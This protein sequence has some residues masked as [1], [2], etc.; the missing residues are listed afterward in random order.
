MVP[1]WVSQRFSQVA[2]AL[3]VVARS[4]ATAVLLGAYVRRGLLNGLSDTD[5]LSDTQSAGHQGTNSWQCQRLISLAAVVEW[6]MLWMEG[7]EGWRGVMYGVSP[8]V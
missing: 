3:P 1:H 6:R 4:T 8:W 5:C 7:E 2:A